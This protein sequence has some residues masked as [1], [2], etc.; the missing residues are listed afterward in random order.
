VY[1]Y[2]RRFLT[3]VLHICTV[4]FHRFL[5]NSLNWSE[6][7]VNFHLLTDKILKKLYFGRRLEF[8]SR[9]PNFLVVCLAKINGFTD[10]LFYLI[11][12]I[13]SLLTTAAADRF[14]NPEHRIPTLF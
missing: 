13:T 1:D 12:M 5:E 9:F 3:L 7:S 6:F 10:H 4:A 11:S 8:R 2:R 14:S